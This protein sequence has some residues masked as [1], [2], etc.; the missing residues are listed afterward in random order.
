MYAH[1]RQSNH[2]KRSIALEIHRRGFVPA[3]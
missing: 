1:W 3:K 2:T